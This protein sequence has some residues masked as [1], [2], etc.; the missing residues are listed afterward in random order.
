M[1]VRNGI[2]LVNQNSF[3]ADVDWYSSVL[4]HESEHMH[5]YLAGKQTIG[6]AAEYH[7]VEVQKRFITKA[8][9]PKKKNY[10]ADLDNSLNGKYWNFVCRKV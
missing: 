3:E 10:F 7:C 8:K 9:T 1:D 5:L 6:E 2:C 4:V